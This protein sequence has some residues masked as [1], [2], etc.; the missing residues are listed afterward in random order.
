MAGENDF[1][2]LGG[3]FK[4]TLGC[5]SYAVTHIYSPKVCTVRLAYEMDYWMKLWLNGKIVQDHTMRDGTP[6][7]GQFTLDVELQPGWNELLLKVSSGS[8]GN[9]FW[10]SINNPGDLRFSP[11]PETP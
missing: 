1:I 10:M 6:I 8:K 3:K 2:D 4:R 5:I 7:K 11:K 9:G